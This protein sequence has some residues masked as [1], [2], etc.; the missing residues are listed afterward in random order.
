MEIWK[1]IKNTKT[2]EISNFGR[3]RNGERILKPWDCKGYKRIDL[4]IGKKLIH[5][6]VAE[7]FIANPGNKPQVNHID[8]DKTNNNVEN[9]EW[10]NNSENQI[11]AH[12]NGLFDMEK[13]EAHL[14]AIREK[15]NKNAVKK[16]SK[17]VNQ[18]SLD[19]ELIGTYKSV[20]EASRQC[21][22]QR[23][24]IMKCIN[25]Q[26][27]HAGGFKWRFSNEH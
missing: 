5:R 13:K 3:V 21:N 23:P 26:R 12:K 17:M 7:A 18:Y 20:A 9:L 27:N 1:K 4:P 2:Y 16:L 22:I 11:H 6:L 25:G 10:C 19:G 24:N 14:K 8:G 15:G